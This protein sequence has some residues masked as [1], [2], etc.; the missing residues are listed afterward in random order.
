MLGEISV[1]IGLFNALLYFKIPLFILKTTPDYHHLSCYIFYI[2]MGHKAPKASTQILL[3]LNSNT[4]YF[5]IIIIFN[6]IPQCP[7]VLGVLRQS[8]F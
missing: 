2:Q 8:I 6:Q 5:I 7:Q 4:S 1:F 3:I